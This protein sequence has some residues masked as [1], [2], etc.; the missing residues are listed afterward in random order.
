MHTY[1]CRLN[2]LASPDVD[3]DGLGLV[4]KV[5]EVALHE[6][7]H[8]RHIHFL[9]FFKHKADITDRSLERICRLHLPWLSLVEL[10]AAWRFR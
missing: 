7:L 9:K 1:F 2:G 8:L 10:G 4:L 6:L 5:P 3:G